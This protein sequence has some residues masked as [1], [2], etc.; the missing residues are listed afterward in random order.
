MKSK[1]SLSQWWVFLIFN[2]YLYQHEN[3]A[4]KQITFCVN[5][6]PVE[7][8]GE[9][10]GNVCF[11]SGWEANHGDDVRA[12]DIVS[13]LTCTNTITLISIKPLL[14]FLKRIHKTKNR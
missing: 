5:A 14:I 1:N 12:V 4:M 11:S 13:T 2:T 8:P 10:L 7:V 3:E 6:N 9:F